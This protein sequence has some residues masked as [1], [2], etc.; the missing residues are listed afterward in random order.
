M[1]CPNCGKEVSEGQSYCNSCGGVLYGPR[2]INLNN[3]GKAAG[4]EQSN[5]ISSIT[6]IDINSL[7]DIGITYEPLEVEKASD[8][9]D[10]KKKGGAKSSVSTIIFILVIFILLTACVILFV[11]NRKLKAGTSCEE[12]KCPETKTKYVASCAEGYYGLAG[13][14]AFMTPNTWRY[15]EIDGGSAL[16][17]DTE[18]I[19]LFDYIEGDITTLEEATVLSDYYAQGYRAEMV[20]DKMQLTVTGEDGKEKKVDKPIIFVSYYANAIYFT[21]FYYQYD[22]KTVIIGQISSSADSESEN[23]EI[24]S[25]ISSIIILDN[26]NGINILKAP[27]DYLKI[28]GKKDT[29][30]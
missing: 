8:K 3:P 21:D 25:I 12:K 30:A 29:N 13:Y 10:K 16:T 26:R 6:G 24:R 27:V 18:S 9:K 19:L 23:E 4:S 7:N 11:T 15:S 22:E 17:N 1:N 5:D 28:I 20:S 2:N 14:Y